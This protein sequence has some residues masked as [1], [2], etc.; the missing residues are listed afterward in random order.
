MIKSSNIIP[1]KNLSMSSSNSLWG[2][3]SLSRT[4][5]NWVFHWLSKWPGLWVITCQDPSFLSDSLFG[6]L[7]GK[8][9]LKI[10]K[11]IHVILPHFTCGWWLPLVSIALLLPFIF[12]SGSHINKMYTPEAQRKYSMFL[13]MPWSKRGKRKEK[14]RKKKKNHSKTQHTKHSLFF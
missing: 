2:L 1:K 7:S 10:N 4:G 13:W 3:S 14:K 12:L 6:S 5:Q 11:P 8:K 9:R